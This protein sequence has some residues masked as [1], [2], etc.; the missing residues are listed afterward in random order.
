M[1]KIPTGKQDFKA[2]LE[3]E[4]LESELNYELEIQEKMKNIFFLQR[5][6]SSQS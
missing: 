6:N 3:N 4:P 2:T 5:G 1:V